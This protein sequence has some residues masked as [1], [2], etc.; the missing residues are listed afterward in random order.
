MKRLSNVAYIILFTTL[1]PVVML[2]IKFVPAPLIMTKLLKYIVLL[3]LVSCSATG[4]KSK[5]EIISVSIPPFRYFVEAIAG[6]DFEVNVMVPPGAGPH[7]Y[8]PAPGQI[9]SLSRSVAYISDGFLGFEIGWLDRFK[10]ANH[11]MKLLTLSDNVDLIK[12]ENHAEEPSAEAADPHFWISPRSAIRIA[13]S[14]ETLLATLKPANAE[15]YKKN[16]ESLNDTINAIDRLADSLFAGFKGKAFMI[17]HPALGYLARDYQLEQMAVE[18][19]GKEPSPSYMKELIDMSREKYI[20]II[21]IQKG[22]D[23][24]NAEAIASETGA[25]IV[26][27]DPLGGNWPVVVREIVNKIHTSLEESIK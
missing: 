20:K 19:E 22:F 11:N 1:M 27:V 18:N 21:F 17:F 4:G 15:Q 12:A 24:K 9:T 8:E 5:K 3:F 25:R 7:I 26:A 23:T 16:L 10:E 6:D 14:V 13:A 2:Y